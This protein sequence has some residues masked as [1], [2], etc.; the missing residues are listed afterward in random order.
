MDLTDRQISILQGPALYLPPMLI[1]IPSGLLIDRVSREGLLTIFT[2]LEIVGTVSTALA[3]NFVTIV[4]A[5]ALIG[6]M[7]AANSVNTSALVAELVTPARRGRAL[8]M[9]G[10]LQVG[11]VSAA[12]ALVEIGGVF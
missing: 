7:Q 9:L 4:F 10:M 3:P 12:F 6:C 1:G 8:M 2:G 5:R 11:G